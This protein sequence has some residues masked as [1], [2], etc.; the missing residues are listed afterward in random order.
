L[1]EKEAVVEFD[2]GKTTEQAVVDK[3]NGLGFQAQVK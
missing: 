1:D 2:S 3:I